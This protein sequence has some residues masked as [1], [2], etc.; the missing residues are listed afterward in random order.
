MGL[1]LPHDGQGICIASG[2]PAGAMY[3]YTN[4]IASN[5][6]GLT[7]GPTTW[8][9]NMV[10]GFQVGDMVKIAWQSDLQ[11]Y[12]IGTITAT[13]SSTITV[14]AAST[15]GATGINWTPWIFTYIPPVLPTAP[16][17]P[18]PAPAP[19]AAPSV[20]SGYSSVVLIISA[21]VVALVGLLF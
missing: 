18:T 7:T 9:V 12:M 15:N 20:N 19:N 10:Q 2:C 4:V 21:S 6:V 3:N 1:G 17:G 14:N 5:N 11:D 8:N 13:T 16:P